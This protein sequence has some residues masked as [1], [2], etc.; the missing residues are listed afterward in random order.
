VALE[1]W[2]RTYRRDCTAGAGGGDGLAALS[3]GGP[4]HCDEMEKSEARDLI[5]PP[6]KKD[7]DERRW[8]VVV[9][10]DRQT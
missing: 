4:E 1:V 3:E 2:P 7:G 9:V 10:R 6:K 5:E 8:R